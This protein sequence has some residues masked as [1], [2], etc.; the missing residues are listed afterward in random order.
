[1]MATNAPNLDF[2]DS[3]TAVSICESCGKMFVK[4]GNRQE[5]CSNEECQKALNAAAFRQ[6]WKLKDGG[7]GE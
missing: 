6:R 1:M 3:K 2:G 7:K 4:T 5:V